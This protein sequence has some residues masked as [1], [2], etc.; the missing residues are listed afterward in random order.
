VLGTSSVDRA[1]GCARVRS[2]FTF[3]GPELFVLLLALAW[4]CGEGGPPPLDPGPGSEDPASLTI[5]TTALPSGTVDLP[6]EA[7]LQ[8]SGGTLPY[9]W[10]TSF[11]PPG[12]TINDQGLISGTPDYPA[13]AHRLEVTVY[14]AASEAASAELTLEVAA[15]SGLRITSLE[16]TT[17]DVNQPYVD[18]V[19][20][21]GGAPPYTFEWVNAIAVLTL[22]PS[23]GILSGLPTSPT[24]PTGE[25]RQ[26]TVTVSDLVGA[27]AFAIVRVGIRPAPLVITTDLRDGRVAERYSVELSAAGG[28]GDRTWTVASGALPPGLAIGSSTL[29]GWNLGGTPTTA[30]SY[31]FTLQVSSGGIVAVRDYTVVIADPPLAIVT[32][33]L[34]RAKVGSPYGVFLVREGG[35]GPFQWDVVDGSLPAGISL[36]EAGELAGTPT[37]AGSVSFEVRVRDAGGQ[38]A[39]A[40]LSLQV[41]P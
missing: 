38:S 21:A 16:L 19:E 11:D 8:A 29:H 41:E 32:S 5:T 39:T 35:S 9:R 1:L 25:G 6:Y 2:T 37:G 34:P 26:T 20:V 27:S 23:T 10:V 7:S 14:D 40:D 36:S 18:T 31:S 13:G 17:G 22:D 3:A 30:G 33:A 28:M 12:L 15:S 4:G 24:G